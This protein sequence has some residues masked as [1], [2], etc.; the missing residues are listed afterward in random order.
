[1]GWSI[2]SEPPQINVD[3]ARNAVKALIPDMF[4][5]HAAGEDATRVCHEVFEQR[6]LFPRKLN[7][8]STRRGFTRMRQSIVKVII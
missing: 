4:N 5:D 8:R 6:I 7:S 1:M 3:N 2:C